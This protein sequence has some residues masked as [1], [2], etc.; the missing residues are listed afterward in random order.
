[1][2]QNYLKWNEALFDNFFVENN[3]INKEIFLYVNNE[4]INEIG[5]IYGLGTYED[6]L[7]CVLLSN[8]DR[9]ALYKYF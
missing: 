8:D 6:F 9:R 4:I 2:W 7:Q 3:S 1:M 5:H